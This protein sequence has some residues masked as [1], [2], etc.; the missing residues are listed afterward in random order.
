MIQLDVVKNEERKVLDNLLQLYLH[1]ISLYF[2]VDFDSSNGL[3][4]YDSLDKYF[5]NSENYAYFIK[6]N[7]EITG[8]VLID[9]NND[10]YIVQEL[11]TL[12]NYKGRG[13]ASDAINKIFDM[14]RGNWVIKVVPNSIQAEIFWNKVIYN[15]TNNNFKVDHVGK[16]ERAV[17]TFNN[18]VEDNGR[19]IL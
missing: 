4:K 6:E 18:E 8:F 9:K 16:Y 14:Y 2:K 7:D 11:F 15:Y 10:Y 19:K 5:D 3:Y 1:E 13:Y 12:N 17:F